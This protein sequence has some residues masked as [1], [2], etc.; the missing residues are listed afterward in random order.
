MC[1]TQIAAFGFLD[2]SNEVICEL[3]KSAREETC[4]MKESDVWGAWGLLATHRAS[5]LLKLRHV[6]TFQKGGPK[7]LLN[8]ILAAKKKKAEATEGLVTTFDF[9]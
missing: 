7:A 8:T 2:I 6:K 9:C 1:G 4:T 3:E 5:Q